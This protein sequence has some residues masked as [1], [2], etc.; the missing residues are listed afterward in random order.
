[1]A[2][3]GSNVLIA[4]YK[5]G[6]TLK[7]TRNRNFEGRRRL[8]SFFNGKL[9]TFTTCEISVLH[10]VSDVNICPA[11]VLRPPIRFLQWVFRRD[12]LARIGISESASRVTYRIIYVNPCVRQT[13]MN[14][15]AW[16]CLASPCIKKFTFLSDQGIPGTVTAENIQWCPS[17]QWFYATWKSPLK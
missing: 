6:S 17:L 12:L 10:T 9:I 5:S 1:M 14:D 11:R 8:R 13:H 4:G 7:L 15:W 3:E 16:W 2:D